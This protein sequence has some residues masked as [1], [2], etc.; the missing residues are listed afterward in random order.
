MQRARLSHRQIEWERFSDHVCCAL[1]VRTSG[2]VR[3]QH[4]MN[5]RICALS[6]S[7]ADVSECAPV[8]MQ[9][10]CR[11]Y[12]RPASWPRWPSLTIGFSRMRRT[13]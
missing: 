2:R 13:H 10:R 1:C 9:L 8:S 5:Y 6:M 11:E 3:V 7:G 12:S 4:K